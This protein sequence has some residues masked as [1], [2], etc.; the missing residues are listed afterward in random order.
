MLGQ[1]IR[2]LQNTFQTAGEYSFGW[3]GTDDGN[4]KVSSGVYFYRLNAGVQNFQ[5]KMILIR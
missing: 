5:K 4:N 1:K 3:D 2:I